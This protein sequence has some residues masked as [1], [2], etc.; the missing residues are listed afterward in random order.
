MSNIVN[1]LNVIDCREIQLF[2][3]SCG[4]SAGKVC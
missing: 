1:G 2:D 3:I 4:L